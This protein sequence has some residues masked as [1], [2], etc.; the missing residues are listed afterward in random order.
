MGLLIRSSEE[1]LIASRIPAVGQRGLRGGSQQSAEGG[2]DAQGS[3]AR[4]R[5]HWSRSPPEQSALGAKQP[6]ERAGFQLGIDVSSIDVTDA[7]EIETR[8]ESFARRSAG[9]LIVL[10][11]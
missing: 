2:A 3:G 1:S 7:T 11:E 9:G 4:R 5:P 6:V 8:L 10:P